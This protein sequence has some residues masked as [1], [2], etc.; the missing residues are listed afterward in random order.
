LNTDPEIE[1][2]STVS[3]ALAGLE[4]DAKARV[5]DWAVKRFSV[6]LPKPEGIVAQNGD[7][8]ESAGREG[9]F[10][11]FVDLFDK[12]GPSSGAERAL[13]GGFWFQVCQEGGTFKSQE[14]NNALKD[15]GHGVSNI[16]DALATLQE[17]N[18]ALVRQVGKTGRSRQ[19]KKTYKLTEAGI[20]EV[21]RM[22]SG[23]ASQE[24]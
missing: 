6:E 9:Q 17:R 16:T 1:A 21:K 11:A 7:L 19:A 24:S 4:D 12:A 22:I 3:K 18:P 20:R 5:L 8:E 2:M 15:V 14:I 13:V 10:D 23:A